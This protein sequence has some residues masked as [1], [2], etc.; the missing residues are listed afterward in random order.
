MVRDGKK[1]TRKPLFENKSLIGKTSKR[2]PLIPQSYQ[3]IPF[4]TF[5][6]KYF[7]QQ[8]YF[9][10][11]DT[12]ASWLANLLDRMKDL[13]NKTAK[14]LDDPSERK[15][16]RLHPIDWSAKN[17]PITINNLLSV[18]QNIKDNIE[19]NFFWQFQLSKGTGRVVGFFDENFSIF[20]VVL[21]DPKHNIQPSKDYG[22]SVDKT[23]IAYTEYERIQMW[24]ADAFKRRLKKCLLEKDCP[25]YNINDVYYNSDMFYASIDPEL[26][27]KYEELIK[28]GMFHAKLEEFLLTEYLKDSE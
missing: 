2:A 23:K 20:Y 18:P 26:K 28:T 12:D 24:I 21:L 8:D 7:G 1:L 3:G 25:L 17:C 19:D 5:S 22:Y 4:I 13:S 6:F 9:G 27:E 14:I 16:Y 11:G 10:I 15:S